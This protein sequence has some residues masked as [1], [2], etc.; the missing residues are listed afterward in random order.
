MPQNITT[1]KLIY[2]AKKEEPFNTEYSLLEYLPGISRI[3]K[4]SLHI[5]DSRF[6]KEENKA[7]A[8]TEYKLDIVYLSDF[9]GKIKCASFEDS[10]RIPFKESFSHD[11]EYTPIT[12]AYAL[13]VSAIPVSPRKVKVKAM[14]Y[15]KCSVYAP[16][17]VSFY[18]A[19]EKK[20]GVCVLEKTITC[21]ESFS[22]D[23]GIMNLQ[24]ELTADSTNPP[25]SE[26]V[27]SKADIH[28]VNA[29]VSDNTLNV[30]GVL[31]MYAL[32]ECAD[33]EGAD[34]SS[35]SYAAVASD[36]S[37][38]A[39]V[40]DLRLKDGQSCICCADVYSAA[41]SCAFDS[42]GESRI[43]TFDVKYILRIT[44]FENKEFV[45]ALDAFSSVCQCKTQSAA[46]QCCRDSFDI[47][48]K[49]TAK[50]TVHTDLNGLSEV[51]ACF[52]KICSVTKEKTSEK[53][54]AAALCTLEVMGTSSQGALVC[55]DTPVTFHIPV[56]QDC[57]D[58]GEAEYILSVSDCICQVKDGYIEVEAQ[59]SINGF[60][61]VI[62]EEQV[63]CAIEEDESAPLCRK[64]G[65]ITV[66][67]PSKDDTVWSVAKKHNIPPEE[68]RQLNKLS[69]DCDKPDGIIIIG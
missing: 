25:A 28:S 14:I 9:G 66:V 44:V 60:C 32:Y 65:E 50:E 47:S 11:G 56:M 4:T 6:L 52:I 12:S 29:R 55:V 42:Y 22:I 67:Y 15:A 63:V 26:I 3:I 53:L 20:D 1:Q 30:D 33:V 58:N 34:Q 43:I 39:E 24:S 57:P 38:S 68:I 48:S 54:F 45:C 61:C 19:D 8:D 18:G 62:A 35:A 21:R 27:Y 46:I 31:S 5:K 41:C 2:E 13:S 16:Q 37:F 64:K 59:F 49:Q 10:I 51:S 69:Q 7:F 17:Q 36:A 40:T 23:S